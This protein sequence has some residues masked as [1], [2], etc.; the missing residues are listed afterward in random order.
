MPSTGISETTWQAFPKPNSPSCVN[1]LGIKLQGTEFPRSSLQRILMRYT[2]RKDGGWF[3]G[4]KV[5]PLA[6]YFILHFQIICNTRSGTSHSYF[7]L[8]WNTVQSEQRIKTAL[9]TESNP[10]RSS[11]AG[12]A[13]AEAGQ[14][15]WKLVS[16]PLHFSWPKMLWFYQHWNIKKK[17][18]NICVR[19]AIK[20]PP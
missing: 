16:A 3:S 15:C 17:K 4:I 18:K 14:E 8:P 1:L 19:Q 11:R 6:S 10:I 7:N 13:S 12:R 5:I 2:K 9:W 20:P